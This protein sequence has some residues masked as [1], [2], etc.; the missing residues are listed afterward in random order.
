MQV[1]SLGQED[2]LEE[3]VATHSSILAWE[4]PWTEEA[5]W[6]Y[7]PWGHKELDMTE[8]LSTCVTQCYLLTL[9]VTARFKEISSLCPRKMFVP[10]VYALQGDERTLLN[11]PISRKALLFLCTVKDCGN[12]H[13]CGIISQ[14]A[15][16]ETSLEG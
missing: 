4:I 9:L 14:V 15:V 2:P 5:G 3:E 16:Q 1:Q 12:I 11:C 13:S 6:L 10:C 8:Q 7:S